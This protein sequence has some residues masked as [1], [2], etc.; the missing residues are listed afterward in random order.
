MSLGAQSDR[1]PL[2]HFVQHQ[3]ESGQES[4][5]EALIVLDQA[6]L[7]KRNPEIRQSV[8][9]NET[10]SG[11]P[12]EAEAIVCETLQSGVVVRRIVLLV[13]D[14]SPFRKPCVEAIISNRITGQLQ[15][16]QNELI[17]RGHAQGH[18]VHAQSGRE[19]CG[20][21]SPDEIDW[22]FLAPAKFGQFLG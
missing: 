8:A 22:H 9:G 13:H 20:S 4:L 2:L 12:N 11:K 17:V 21:K 1:N 18:P 6:P 7:N 19:R 15:P 16:I 5:P 14:N 10:P 3:Q